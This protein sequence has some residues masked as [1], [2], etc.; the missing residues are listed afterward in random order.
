M[1]STHRDVY[2]FIYHL[3]DMPALQDVKQ[4]NNKEER[5]SQKLYLGNTV[6]AYMQGEYIHGAIVCD[7]FI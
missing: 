6:F 7:L 5:R 4:V 1:P 3:R 2:I